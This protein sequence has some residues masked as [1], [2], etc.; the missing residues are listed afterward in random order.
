MSELDKVSWRPL[1]SALL[2]AHGRQ[3]A[4]VCHSP[5][6]CSRAD[7]ERSFSSSLWGLC[8]HT[9]PSCSRS[10]SDLDLSVAPAGGL[11]GPASPG[12]LH[13]GQGQH[14][15][16][17][18]RLRRRRSRQNVTAHEHSSGPS[19]TDVG[20]AGN[21]AGHAL[22]GQLRTGRGHQ[23]HCQPGLHAHLLRHHCSDQTAGQKALLT[24]CGCAGNGAGD[25]LCG[26]L[27]TWRG[28]PCHPKPGIQRSPSGLG[29]RPGTNRA[30][31]KSGPEYMTLL[32]YATH[33]DTG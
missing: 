22:C 6:T 7:D 8:S 17:V 20:C 13:A 11:A 4:A 3:L 29:R 2:V 28:H 12:Q 23:R 18:S 31:D 5:R 25:A 33:E 21:G 26:Q 15:V 14:P 27:C 19:V 9:C 30:T 10:G 24:L 16:R 32:S 1:C